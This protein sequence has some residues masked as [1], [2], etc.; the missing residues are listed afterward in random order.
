MKLSDYQDEYLFLLSAV[1]VKAEPL[2][3]PIVSA[4]EV[5]TKA[6]KQRA[7]EEGARIRMS[8]SL[9][10]QNNA[11]H[12]CHSQ[13][14]G[15]MCH[16]EFGLN[17]HKEYVKNATLRDRLTD[18]YWSSRIGAAVGSTNPA[19][20]RFAN[21]PRGSAIQM[22]GKERGIT[23]HAETAPQVVHTAGTE[24]GSKVD[25]FP[26]QKRII[27]VSDLGVARVAYL[28]PESS[29]VLFEGDI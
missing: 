8:Y 11:H 16:S 5:L 23:P 1:E 6:D 18:P 17:P 4:A 2:V 24:L 22:A 21:R 14:C 20:A 29:E 19:D 28:H 15:C 9:F 26:E 13:Q 27:F 3:L 25:L 10:C 12:N 7:I